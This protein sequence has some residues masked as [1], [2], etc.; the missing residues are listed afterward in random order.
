MCGIAGMIYRDTDRPVDRDILGRMAGAIAHRGPDAEGFFVE[1]HVGIAH[2]RLSIIDLHGGDQPIGNEDGRIQV[3]FN[4]EIYNFRELRRDLE[5]RGH[6]FRTTSDTE[7]IVHAY[8]EFGDACVERLRG[9]FAFAIWDGHRR[10]V[11]LARDRVGIKPLFVSLNDQRLVFGSE[12]KS[13]LAHG[14]MQRDVDPAAVDDYFNYGV[15][16]GS[17]SIFR[18]VEKLLPAHSLSIDVENWQVTRRRYWQLEFA[19][20]DSL[21]CEEWQE[22]LLDK[23]QESVRTHLVADV[24]VGSFLSGG[25]DSSVVTGLASAAL[26]TPIQTFSIGFREARFSELD[27]AREIAAHFGTEHTEQ[28]VEA[29]AAELLPSLAQFYDEPFADSSALPTYLVSQLASRDVKVVLS[30]DGGDEALG[31][32]SRYAHD[33]KEASIRQLLPGWLRRPWLA[34]LANVW[35]KADWLPRP[36]RLKTFLTNMSLGDA[37][38]YANT[39]SLCRQPLRS[40]LLHADVREQL[41]SHK[42]SLIAANG[43]R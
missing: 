36:L 34:A 22:R 42:G 23:L 15:I 26:P 11:L 41:V 12:L 29:D 28:I 7:V 30:G 10:R 16:P 27:A 33:L 19:P 2:R 6:Q 20:D 5:S 21:T 38:A 31:G 24:P 32:Y 1:R 14:D 17:R 18:G 35:P 40:R 39:L 4:G 37:D 13:V 43:Y 8:E 9:M 25:M 3:V